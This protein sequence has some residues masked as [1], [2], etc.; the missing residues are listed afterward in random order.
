MPLIKPPITVAENCWIA[1]DA[2]LGPNVNIGPSAIVGARAVVFRD[3]PA[4][5]IV[6]GNPATIISNREQKN[7][8]KSS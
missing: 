5:A 8:E 1:A 3:I 7:S 2:F 4:G 6:I